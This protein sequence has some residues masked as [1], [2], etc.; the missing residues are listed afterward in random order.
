MVI[1]KKVKLLGTLEIR[2]CKGRDLR[3]VQKIGKQDPFLQFELGNTR[4]RTK[5]DK[6]GGQKP[7]WN[8]RISFE[9]PEGVHKVAV[10]CYD[11]NLR[12]HAF[13]G[14]REI[15]FSPAI[16]YY[17]LDNWFELK[18]KGDPAGEVYLEFT[19]FP[20]VSSTPLYRTENHSTHTH[21]HTHHVPNAD[22]INDL[23]CVTRMAKKIH[24]HYHMHP[25][26]WLTK[27]GYQ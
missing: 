17:Q 10:K 5:A 21:T 13:I 9:V 24:H 11:Q 8:E 16:T 15:D 14:E 1:K 20:V 7:T 19:F 6:N 3:V 18:D 23:L 4:K 25:H 22:G 2:P 12:E 26:Q 27:R